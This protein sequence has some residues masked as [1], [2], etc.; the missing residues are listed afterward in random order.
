MLVIN[1]L[2]HDS[3]TIVLFYYNNYNNATRNKNQNTTL[4]LAMLFYCSNTSLIF[5][6]A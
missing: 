3:I 1:N 5:N 6:R 2:R 4:S